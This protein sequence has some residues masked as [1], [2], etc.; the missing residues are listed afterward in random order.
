VLLNASYTFEN[1]YSVLCDD[2]HATM[3]A[4][5]YL[6]AKGQRNILFLYHNHNYS[7][8]KKLAGCKAALKSAGLPIQDKLIH[9]YTENKMSIHDIRDYIDAID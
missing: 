2:Y 3:I 6:L 7:G 1:I 4:T 8:L 9:Y 5:Q